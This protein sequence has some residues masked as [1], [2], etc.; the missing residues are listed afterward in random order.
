MAA[1]VGRRE[2]ILIEQPS[3]R[4]DDELMGRTDAF[5]TV[6]VPAAPGLGPGDLA[7]AR[8]TRATTATLFG[9]LEA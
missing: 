8:I 3:K 9:T 1:Q 5:R 2:R 7:V 6:I 4:A